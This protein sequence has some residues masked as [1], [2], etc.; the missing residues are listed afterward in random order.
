M[1]KRKPHSPRDSAFALALD[2]A[3]EVVLG[4]NSTARTHA[5]AHARTRGKGASAA[6]GQ[7]QGRAEGYSDFA[8]ANPLRKLTTHQARTPLSRLAAV[9]ADGFFG[10]WHYVGPG[11][12]PP[13]MGRAVAI[14]DED[15]AMI[16]LG[17]HLGG[18]HFEP[19]DGH[20]FVPRPGALWTPLPHPW[21]RA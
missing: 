18:W 17:I 20:V 7:A 10:L 9:G 1:P 6:N 4:E 15:Q 16:V 8:I 2:S 3:G 12:L 21:Q 19:P 5:H 11:H 14:L 13:D